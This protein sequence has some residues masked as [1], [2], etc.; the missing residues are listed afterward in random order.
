MILKIK[1]SSKTNKQRICVINAAT[2]NCPNFVQIFKKII[3]ICP[4]TEYKRLFA[5]FKA[6]K[7]IN[8]VV[9]KKNF[10]KYHSKFTK[11]FK[12]HMPNHSTG[13]SQRRT[14]ANLIVNAGVDILVV[15][16]HSSQKSNNIAEGYAELKKKNYF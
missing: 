4:K 3:C 13:H 5:C 10:P 12:H 14:S 6:D 8:Q 16:Q 9:D 1:T 15:K 11:Y 7:S 2:G